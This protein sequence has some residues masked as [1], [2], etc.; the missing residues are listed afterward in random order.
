MTTLGFNKKYQFEYIRASEL[1]LTSGGSSD[2]TA[3][4][5]SDNGVIIDELGAQYVSFGGTAFGTTVNE[6]G[7]QFVEAGGTAIN[8]TVNSGGLQNVEGGTAIATNLT[9]DGYQYVRAGGTSVNTFLSAVGR[10]CG[11]DVVDGTAINTMLLHF[12]A[13]TVSFG[14][15]S[16]YTQV[17]SGGI[18][19]IDGGT[20]DYTTVYN[21]GSQLLESGIANSTTVSSG[22]RQSVLVLAGGVADASATQVRSG[23]VQTVF[24]NGIA[25]RTTIFGGGFA[26]VMSGG[27]LFSVTI[28]AGP[29]SGGGIVAGLR[30]SRGWHNHFRPSWTRQRRQSR[31]RRTRNAAR[32]D[33]RLCPGGELAQWRHDRP[34]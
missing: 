1:Q 20:T 23:G 22:G 14:A 3:G 32:R 4:V 12:G 21:S 15:A 2:T 31:D 24:P 10:P 8:T 18:E 13:L 7:Q 11:E 6:G 26:E 16:K 30:V 34:Y 28:N 25:A 33:L 27:E 19:D 17:N 9:D 5:H 29:G